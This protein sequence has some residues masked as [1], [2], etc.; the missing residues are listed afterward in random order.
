[1]PPHALLFSAFARL[2]CGPREQFQNL[3]P[4]HSRRP[5]AGCGPRLRVRFDRVRT[6]REQQLHHVDTSPPAFPSK[7][8]TLG[9]RVA[10]G[11]TGAG[12][13]QNGGRL[14][15][16]AVIARDGLMPD[17]LGALWSAVMRSAPGQDQLEA[18]ATFGLL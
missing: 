15:T 7:R 8:C 13:E 17:G 3:A 16:P 10:N 14:N 6:A 9:Q 18:L 2:L 12:T 4:V 1:M 11:E 5:G